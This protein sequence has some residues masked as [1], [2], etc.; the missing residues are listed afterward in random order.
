LRVAA[1]LINDLVQGGYDSE[2]VLDVVRLAGHALRH[3]PQSQYAGFDRA[4]QA[5]EQA[6]KRDHGHYHDCSDYQ[7]NLPE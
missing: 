7:Q 1:Q 4:D 5:Q 6:K 2:R 3:I